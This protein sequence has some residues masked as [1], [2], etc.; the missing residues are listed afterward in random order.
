MNQKHHC[1]DGFPNGVKTLSVTIPQGNRKHTFRIINS[2][3]FYTMSTNV[4]DFLRRP[5]DFKN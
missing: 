3:M 1:F 5:A 2:I 4:S